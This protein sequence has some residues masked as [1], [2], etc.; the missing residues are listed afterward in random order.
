M[1]KA[2]QYTKETIA[3]IGV[4][5]RNFPAFEVGDTIAISQI[6][7]EGDKQRIQVF[8]GDVIA[9]RGAGVSRMFTVRKIAANSVAVERIFPYHSPLI[10]GIELVRQGKIRRAKLYYLRDLVGK[11]ARIKENVQTRAQKQRTNQ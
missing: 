5:E 11:A 6:I 7:K 8:Q 1:V 9:M 2:S 4:S 10:E 3:A